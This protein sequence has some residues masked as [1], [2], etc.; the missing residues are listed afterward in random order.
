MIPQHIEHTHFEPSAVN[1]DALLRINR[2]C[3]AR[4]R[5]TPLPPRPPQVFVSY[6]EEA[7]LGDDW[8]LEVLSLPYTTASAAAHVRL[9]SP[10]GKPL[11]EPAAV[12]LPRDDIHAETLRVP[13]IGL[14]GSRV[15]LVQARL[16]S[17][18]APTNDWSALYPVIVRPGHLESLRTLHIPLDELAAAPVLTLV[19][20][21]GTRAARVRFERW[22]LAGRVE[23]LRN[24]WPVAEK[25]IAHKGAPS[26]T[27]TLPLPKTDATPED[28]Y[29]ARY[30][31]LSGDVSWSA[32]CFA[33]APGGAAATNSQ[34]VIVS[35]SDFDEGW[36]GGTVSRLEKPQI[37]QCPVAREETYA[38]T[39][40]M[41]EGVG[42]TLI[43]V[44]G[45]RVTAL[46]GSHHKGMLPDPARTPR[47]VSGGARPALRF[48][49]TN[50]CV[51]L[52][53][54]SMPYGPFTLEMAVRLDS[55]HGAAMTL[56]SDAC[57]VS[58]QLTPDARVR[59]ARRKD[60]VTGQRKIPADR[61]THL[62]AVYDGEHMRLTVD[63]VPD[64][65]MSAETRLL[66]I[67]SLPVIGNG[68][69][70]SEGF[71]GLIGGFHLQ[72]GALAPGQHVL[73]PR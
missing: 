14:D 27:V 46:L 48:D 20:E 28:M 4:W 7:N 36:W 50:D 1:R 12:A 25:E 9:L 37:A 56:F 43:S 66:R 39:Y 57:G 55:G 53:S 54:R 62:A 2:D 69:K 6:H 60:S 24:G 18:A 16:E 63:G 65:E 10:A 40:P 59:C 52:P 72:C 61:W 15:F 42:D 30:S 19:T 67:N 17:A 49:G 70:G 64:G 22:N 11:F 26:V 51:I 47:W 29:L 73:R 38:L 21:S 31:N 35:G 3:A 34:P 45:W 68:E 23:I 32:P 44:S 33:H 13:Q 5:G 8:T 58:L 41:D 71:R